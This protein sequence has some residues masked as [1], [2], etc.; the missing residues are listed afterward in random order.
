MRPTTITAVALVLALS[1]C[2]S[3]GAI[4]RVEL[5]KPGP[6]FPRHLIELE[7]ASC[8]SSEVVAKTRYLDDKPSAQRYCKCWIEVLSEI[9]D[10]ENIIVFTDEF[11]R[12]SPSEKT[13]LLNERTQR[14]CY[15]R[16]I[17]HGA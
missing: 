17:L 3:T 13:K 8:V 9:Y 2:A 4:P 6:D 11:R 12:K 14:T 7:I 1:A 5:S 15:N 16:A 10:W